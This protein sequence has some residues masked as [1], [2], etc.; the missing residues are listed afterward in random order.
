MIRFYI[1][2]MLLVGS[3]YSMEQQ[4]KALQAFKQYV[5]NKNMYALADELLDVTRWPKE[6]ERMMTEVIQSDEHCHSSL[7]YSLQYYLADHRTISALA[8]YP[9]AIKSDNG[10]DTFHLHYI[11]ARAKQSNMA[12]L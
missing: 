7:H 9:F 12:K 1:V 4:Q 5:E 11:P 6:L 10:R 3:L 2:M 8:I